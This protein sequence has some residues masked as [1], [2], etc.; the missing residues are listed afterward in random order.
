MKEKVNTY[1]TSTYSVPF[2]GQGTSLEPLCKEDQ[3]FVSL[4]EAFSLQQSG[5]T[6]ELYLV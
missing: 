6:E 2:Q 5:N 4:S 1:L 3:A